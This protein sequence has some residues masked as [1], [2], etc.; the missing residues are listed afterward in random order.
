MDIIAQQQLRDLYW[1]YKGN[2]IE[3]ERSWRDVWRV[4]ERQKMLAEYRCE[5]RQE[6]DS[7][8]DLGVDGIL[9]RGITAN[10]KEIRGSILDRSRQAHDRDK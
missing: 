2:Q 9:L 10:L 4:L 7:L 8:E 3:E 1:Y 5:I 6:R